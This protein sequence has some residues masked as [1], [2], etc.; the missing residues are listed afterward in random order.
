MSRDTSASRPAQKPAT[1]PGNANN[2]NKGN[3]GNGSGNGNIGGGGGNVGNG[4]R[5]NGN[6]INNGNRNNVNINGGNRVVVANPV[7][8]GPAWGWNGGVVWGP[9]YGYW[10][11]GFWGAWAVGALTTAVIYGSIVNTTT[12]E[13]ITSYEVQPNSPGATL[14]SNYHLTQT[15]CGPPNL[16]VIHGPNDSLICA[17]PN[18]LVSAGTYSIDSSNLTLVSQ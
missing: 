11:G 3:L 1:T 17:N 4:N 8:R 6:N 10:G 7:Y 2:I 9:A 18:D 16:V 14:L 12:H 15:Q 5:G 13:T